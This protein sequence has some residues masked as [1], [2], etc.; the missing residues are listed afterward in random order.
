K[1]RYGEVV[2]CYLIP[3]LG[4]LQL[5]KL[6]PVQIQEAYSEIRGKDGGALSPHTRRY[7]NVILKS[8]LGR[9]VKQQLLARNPAETQRMP[10]VERKERVTLTVDQSVRLLKSISHM[11]LY[12]PVLLALTT[13]MRRGE[14]LALR[15]EPCGLCRA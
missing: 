7:I 4:Q 11:H 9:A 2:R 15:R 12:W 3:A 10:R 8:A 14:I 5:S 1:E 13:G 6:V